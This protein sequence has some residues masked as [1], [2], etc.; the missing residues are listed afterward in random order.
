ME[1]VTTTENTGIWLSDVS[2][3]FQ[4][5]NV[6]RRCE[7]CKAT[8]WKQLESDCEFMNRWT[9][10]TNYY[11]MARLMRDENLMAFPQDRYTYMYD[12]IPSVNNIESVASASSG[13]DANRQ[14]KTWTQKFRLSSNVRSFSGFQTCQEMLT[15]AVHQGGYCLSGGQVMPQY[16]ITEVMCKDYEGQTWVSLRSKSFIRWNNRC[17]SG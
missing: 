7:M 11:N 9:V 17:F 3:R 10:M 8:I 2:L 16:G 6:T 13:V 4:F 5:N 12:V 1:Q 14:C 15:L